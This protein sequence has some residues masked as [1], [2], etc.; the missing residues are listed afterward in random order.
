MN[1]QNQLVKIVL[2]ENGWDV[3]QYNYMFDFVDR[4]YI[5]TI[6][7]NILMSD[8]LNW[9]NKIINHSLAGDIAMEIYPVLNNDKLSVV[10]EE[11]KHHLENIHQ[12]KI[13]DIDLGCVT[14]EGKIEPELKEFW[15]NK[16]KPT[17][18]NP[19]HLH[20]GIYSFV[21]YLSVPEEIRQEHMSQKGTSVTRGLIQFLSSRTKS[22][23]VFNPEK[24]NIFIFDSSH[25]HQV[26][27]FYSDA[28]R[29]SVAGNVHGIKFSDGNILGNFYEV[30]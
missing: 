11:L 24:G 15:V 23:L 8:V 17:E 18:Y 20:S 27:P 13:D 6:Q 9:D 16:Q 4:N 29:I 21:Y 19:I 7:N 26:Y 10:K 25:R 3:Y 28:V 30:L 22:Q 14:Y 5:S 12:S 1:K 2:P